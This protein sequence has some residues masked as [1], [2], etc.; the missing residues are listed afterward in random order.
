MSFARIIEAVSTMP[1]KNTGTI[2]I[3]GIAG[4][5]VIKNPLWM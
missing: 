4:I 2:G 1:V 3:V 5:N